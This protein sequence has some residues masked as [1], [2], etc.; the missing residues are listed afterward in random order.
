M[1][2]DGTLVPLALTSAT[3]GLLLFGS[4]WALRHQRMAVA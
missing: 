2:H 3:L 1:S 4:A